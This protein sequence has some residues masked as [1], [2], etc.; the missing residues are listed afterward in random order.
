M[1]RLFTRIA[2]WV[3]HLAGMPPTFAICVLIIVAW[4]L[5]GPIFGFSDTWQLVINTGTTI[6]TFLMVFLIQNT[7]NRDSAAIQ[8]KLDELIRVSRAHN[9]FIGI[10]HLTESEVEEIRDKCEK[11]AKRHDREVAQAAVKK[12]AAGKNGSKKKQPERPVSGS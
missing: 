8:T 5:S 10:E 9:T 4:A 11:A 3:A 12:A 6:V 7:Q 1:E 2:N